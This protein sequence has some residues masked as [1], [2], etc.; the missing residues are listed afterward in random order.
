V[1][2]VPDN[3]NPGRE[4]A[5]QVALSLHGIA[6][7]IKVVELPGVPEKGD[8]SDWL[9]QGGTKDKL[10]ELV[11]A[12]SEWKP[13]PAGKQPKPA[14]EAKKPEPPPYVAFRLHPRGRG[15]PWLR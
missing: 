14:T 6:K 7:N 4:H 8:W 5:Q 15:G 2:I 13:A 11:K 10:A 3:D 9:D 12:A 1:Y